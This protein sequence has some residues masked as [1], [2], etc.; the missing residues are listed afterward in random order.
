MRHTLLPIL[1]IAVAVVP[2]AAQEP[3]DTPTIQTL[4]VFLDCNGPNCDRDHFRREIAWVNWA[5]DR[6]DADVHLLITMQQTG[7]NGW[8]YT[9]DYIGL[10]AFE[11]VNKTLAHTS[12]ANDTD[13]EVR[14]QLTLTM[15]L[16]LVQY[17]ETSSVAPRLQILYRPVQA[18][19]PVVQE[20]HDP[21]NLWMFRVGLNGNIEGEAQQSSYSISGSGS[22][23]RVS[24]NLKINID[25]RGQ[26]EH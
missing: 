8:H 10:G 11:G 15:A 22:A 6:N 24:D 14:E 4:S 9:L 16:G 17:A 21:W 3:T 12:D 25:L 23:D 13:A 18:G 7:G 19:E 26:Y 1:L 20:E 2:S 5:R